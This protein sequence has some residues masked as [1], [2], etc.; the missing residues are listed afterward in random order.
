MRRLFSISFYQ[1]LI[2]CFFCGLLAGTVSAN[3][4]G[5]EIL[6]GELSV[7]EMEG[8]AGG[9]AGMTAGTGDGNM[10]FLTGVSLNQEQRKVLWS[11]VFRQRAK[12]FGL[13][14]LVGMT[15][16]SALGFS[17]AAFAG[18][19][20]SGFLLSMVTLEIGIGGMPIFLMTLLPQ[21]LCY[22]PVWIVLALKSADGLEQMKLRLWPV[23]AAAVLAGM[24]LETW[25]N[26]YFW[27]FMGTFM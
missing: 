9:T 13:A 23:L 2:L 8:A 4:L 3:L 15:P 24:C 12:E 7:L 21:W 1:V 6:A 18:G 11:Y 22:A 10:E 17:A 5:P 25:V 19:L 14:V 20:G 27:K 16:F 26:P